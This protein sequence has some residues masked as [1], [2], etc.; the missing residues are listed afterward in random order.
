MKVENDKQIFFEKVDINRVDNC[1]EH[2][3][4][5]EYLEKAIEKE[6]EEINKTSIFSEKKTGKKRTDIFDTLIDI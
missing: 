4:F 2:K 6:V 5:L 1:E 3:K